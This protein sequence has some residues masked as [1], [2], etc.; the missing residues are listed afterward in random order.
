MVMAGRQGR[1][2][3]AHSHLVTGSCGARRSAR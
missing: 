3:A 2:H 1:L